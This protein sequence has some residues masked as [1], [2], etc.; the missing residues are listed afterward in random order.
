MG[1]S[2]CAARARASSPQGNQSTGLWACWRR[3]GLVS[4]TSRLVK[5]G[6]AVMTRSSL[7]IRSAE[8]A[9]RYA[10]FFVCL[11]LALRIPNPLFGGWDVV[12]VGAD[13]GA[14]ERDHQFRHHG[15]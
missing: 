1:R 3:Y 4:R 10:S 6:A 7:G 14:G 5:R 2:S 12:I 9:M 8:C 15:N 13:A 11:L